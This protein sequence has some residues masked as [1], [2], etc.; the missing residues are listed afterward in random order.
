MY[1]E[2]GKERERKEKKIENIRKGGK[3]TLGSKEEKNS[4]K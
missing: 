1:G 4:F 3:N 2:T